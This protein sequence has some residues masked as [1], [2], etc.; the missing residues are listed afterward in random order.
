MKQARKKLTWSDKP[1]RKFKQAERKQI[2]RLLF[3][4]EEF[5]NEIRI[6]YS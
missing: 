1:L 3:Q 4:V 5:I 2:G 6:M